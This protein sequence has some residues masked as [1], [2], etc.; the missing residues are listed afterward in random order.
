MKRRG[1]WSL[2]SFLKLVVDVPY[3]LL[4][5]A[6]PLILVVSLVGALRHRHSA[7]MSVGMPVSFQLDPA[8]H[9]FV[10]TRHDV[11]AVSIEGAHGTLIL[12]TGVA[13]KSVAWAELVLVL[14]SLGVIVFVLN[15]LRAILRTLRDQNP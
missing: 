3:Y 2:A 10:A 12:R 11:Q 4:L 8:T 5:V 1:S 15:R 7:S 9:H 6:I 14:I 13:I